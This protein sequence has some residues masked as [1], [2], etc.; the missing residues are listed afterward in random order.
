MGLC[1][2]DP[3]DP[4]KGYVAGINADLETLPIRRILEAAA[5]L[6]DSVTL[7]MPGKGKQGGMQTFDFTGMGEAEYQAKYADNLTGQ[8]L[9]MQKDFGP[10]YV[11]QRL[12]ELEQADPAGA[13]MRRQLWGAIQDSAS[14]T[15]ARPGNQ[16]LEDL[17]LGE[18]DRGGQLNPETAERVSQRVMGGQ[19]ARGNYLGNAAAAEES[20][21]LASA[22][23]REAA[24]RQAQAMA[25][26]TGGL[27]PEDAAYREQQQDLGNL[28]AFISGET[29]VA[30]FRQLSGA[31]GGAV[32][33]TST[34]PGVGVDP[35]AG[36]SGIQN[37]SGVWAADQQAR[38]NTVNP[39]TAGLSGA[40]GGLNVWAGLGGRAGG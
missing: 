15:T 39:W 13:A 5:L 23:E 16:S 19:V 35:N 34:G 8:L 28:G 20:G 3:P 36:W 21:A 4:A 9:Q 17:I 29:P 12:A 27:S 38:Q 1:G 40:M 31:A 32:P 14:S 11:Q 25:F 6:G 2:N 24:S 22:T 33:F 30:Q 26:L 37:Q 10:A 7:D 18:L